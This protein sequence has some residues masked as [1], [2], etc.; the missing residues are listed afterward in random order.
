MKY[1]IRLVSSYPP[2]VCGIGRFSENLATALAKLSAVGDIR[3]A[4]IADDERSYS[5]PVD[6]VID[7][8][9][10]KSWR[11]A[12]SDIKAKA[13]T[14]DYPHIV[15]L[16]HEYGLDGRDAIGT[17]YVD[18]AKS[19]HDEGLMT[20]AYLHTI[21]RHPNAHQSR[22]LQALVENTDGLLV[23]LSGAI[24]IL[25]ATYG[26]DRSK[27]THIDHG[28]RIRD[29]TKTDRLHIKQEYGLG[30]KFL[31]TTLGLLSPDKGVHYGVRAYARLLDTSCTEK[32]RKDIVYLI[33]GQYHPGFV[34][35]GGGEA[36]REYRRLLHETLAD[37]GLRYCEVEGL[38][39]V[40]WGEYDVCFL[41]AYLNEDLLRA[42]Y[43]ATN[44]MILA[45]LNPEQVSSGILAD[46]IGSGRVPI[47]SKTMFAK[48][49][50]GVESDDTGAILTSRG[51]LVDPAEPS[52]DQIAQGLDYLVF[53]EKERFEME[54]NART[55]GYEMRWDNSAWKLMQLI[56]AIEEDKSIVTGR[57][58]EFTRQRESQLQQLE[59]KC[60]C[61]PPV[62]P[63]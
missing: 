4:A 20:L 45:Y 8:Y 46:T 23:T 28:I 17:N 7:Q 40:D 61:Q 26:I 39:G 37:S 47:S 9:D 42:L 63:A 6:I 31:A 14:D 60:A 25:N 21:L 50:L 53:N 30:G 27:V 19:L 43:G 10:P 34:E 29:I 52:V 16:Q 3:V 54:Q 59:H 5:I 36:Y 55:R 57:G 24:D 1:N 48:E 51:V 2:R 41:E 12:A 13:Q 18:M 44:T 35:S 62:E 58:R 49:L 38:R 15:I 11:E 33:A 22:T 56:G 32:Q